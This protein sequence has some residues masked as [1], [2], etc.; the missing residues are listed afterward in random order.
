MCTWKTK[1]H[2]PKKVMDNHY[3]TLKKVP[4]F[5]NEDKEEDETFCEVESYEEV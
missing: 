3:K 4:H 2:D 5:Q 1:G